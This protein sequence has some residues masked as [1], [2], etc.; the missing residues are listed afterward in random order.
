MTFLGSALGFGSALSVRYI[1]NGQKERK[2][3]KRVHANVKA[4]LSR[5]HTHFV[6]VFGP[7]F[8]DAKENQPILWDTPIWKSLVYTGDLTHLLKKNKCF[9]LDVLGI[10]FM[11][12]AIKQTWIE[13]RYSQ[14][15]LDL[16]Q[17]MLEKIKTLLES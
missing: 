14:G 3:I 15:R 10:Y 2:R 5:I 1:I 4:E 7:G 9:Y 17:E 12:H 11:L 8:N 6:D 16:I 13:P